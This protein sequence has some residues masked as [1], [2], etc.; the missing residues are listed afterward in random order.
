M[1][2]LQREPGSLSSDNCRAPRPAWKTTLCATTLFPGS[3]P[4][5]ECHRS[6]PSELLVELRG[7]L[8]FRS[9]ECEQTSSPGRAEERARHGDRSAGARFHIKVRKN[10]SI[11]VRSARLHSS[12]D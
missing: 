7:L 6:R 12:P 1:V 9:V 11:A 8:I 5:M 10:R 3:E 4:P 2:H